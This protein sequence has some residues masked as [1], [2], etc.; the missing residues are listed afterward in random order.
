MYKQEIPM[1]IHIAALAVKAINAENSHNHDALTPELQH[2]RLLMGTL[3][4]RIYRIACESESRFPHIKGALADLEAEAVQ[5]I[6]S[7]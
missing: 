3:V 5:F 4:H 1:L 7:K 2:V 6:S